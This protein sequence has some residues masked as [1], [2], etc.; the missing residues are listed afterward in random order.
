MPPVTSQRGIISIDLGQFA[1]MLRKAALADERAKVAIGDAFE[2]TAREAQA[3]IKIQMPVDTG[4]AR[5]SWGNPGHGGIW[6]LDKDKLTNT[7]GGLD[8]IEKLNQGS[9]KQAP[10]GFL[11][12]ETRKAVEDF[13]ARV[14]QKI[15]QAGLF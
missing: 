14:K 8:Y 2:E 13:D 3:R 5:R 10:A 12:I 4:A 6:E 7:Q 15:K 11:D 9:S 1:A